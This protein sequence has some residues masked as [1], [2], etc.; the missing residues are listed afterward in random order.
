VYGWDCELFGK[1]PHVWC[2]IVVRLERFLKY[3]VG[4]KISHLWKVMLELAKDRF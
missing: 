4:S 2:G 1:V 3:G